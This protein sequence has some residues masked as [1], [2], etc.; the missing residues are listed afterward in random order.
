MMSNDEKCEFLSSMETLMTTKLTAFEQRMEAS[1][2]EISQSQLS[3]IQQNLSSSDSYTFRRK[4]NEEQHKVNSQ[5]LDR[6]RDA[7]GY[8][9][10]AA[11]TNDI[12]AVVSAQGKIAEGIDI[13][14]HRQKLVKLAD[15]SESGWRVVQEYEAHPLADGSDDEKKIYRAQMTAD[16]KLK[17][18][19]RVK[20]RRYAPYTYTAP[21]ELSSTASSSQN[22]GNQFTQGCN[23]SIHGRRPGNC[24]RCGRAGH[25]RIECKA[26]L[27]DGSQMNKDVQISRTMLNSVIEAFKCTKKCALP[28]SEFITP[29]GMLKGCYNHWKDAGANEYLLD[30]VKQGYKL[31]FRH[32]PSS[33]FLKNNMSARNDPLFVL[34][35]IKNLLAKG[36]ISELMDAPYIVNPLTVAYGTSGKPRLV[37]D[38]RHLN[39]EL[40]KY[41]VCFEDQ[42]VAKQ[43]FSTGDYVFAFDI[44]SAYHHI[45]IFPDHRTYLGFSWHACEG[46]TRYFVFNVLPFGIATAGFIFTK[47]L[48][49][50]LTKW[51]S[52]GYRVVLFLDDGLG[53]GSTCVEA[54]AAS[55]FIH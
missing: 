47:L 41:K 52:L 28:S 19:R 2:R 21:G 40:F 53:G 3:H 51:R 7:D 30:V 4:G 25:W 15:S 46:S 12:A 49:V 50:A 10:D 5:V 9:K 31:P 13:V 34:G 26:V 1:Q 23:Q 22:R 39:L 16:R 48:R 8:L 14:T 27:P 37:L 32:V 33:V 24:F 43:L 29:V 45:M 55:D 35:E 38:C 54:L 18:D 11:R 6:L 17:Q 44:R 20:G 36:C 42:S